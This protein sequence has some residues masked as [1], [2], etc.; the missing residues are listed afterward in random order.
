MQSY[1]SLSPKYFTITTGENVLN[2]VVA[3]T[4][5]IR[6]DVQLYKLLFYYYTM[7]SCCS[8]IISLKQ[9]DTNYIE[10]V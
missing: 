4:Y 10:W 7:I 2:L 1:R 3:F 5:Y 9:Y 8:K 6:D